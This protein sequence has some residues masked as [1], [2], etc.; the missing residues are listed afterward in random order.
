LDWLRGN[1]VYLSG[2]MLIL[3][4]GFHNNILGDAL[5]SLPSTFQIHLRNHQKNKFNHVGEVV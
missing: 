4:F 3:N 5:S 2:G 1:G